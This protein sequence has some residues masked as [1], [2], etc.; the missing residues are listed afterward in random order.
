[1]G[2][3]LALISKS[4]RAEAWT[5]AGQVGYVELATH[6]QFAKTFAQAMYLG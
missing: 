6:P 3:K 1:M 5:L 2:A 4:K